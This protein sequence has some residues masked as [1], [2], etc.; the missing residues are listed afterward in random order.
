M[1]TIAMMMM[2]GLHGSRFSF[3]EASERQIWTTEQFI[4]CSGIQGEKKNIPP[5]TGH[6]DL[7]LAA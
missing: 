2:L 3:L 1:T 5:S 7:L 4:A 6:E